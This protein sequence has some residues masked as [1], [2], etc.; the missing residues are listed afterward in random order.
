VPM[1]PGGGPSGSA[2]GSFLCYRLKCP[3]PFPPDAET[4]DQFG[5]KRV[6]S[7]RGAAFLCAR[8]ARGA[9]TIV[10][11]TTTTTVPGASQFSS[12]NH[13]CEGTCGNG[14]HCSAVVSG[15]ACECRTTPCGNADQPQCNGFCNP[16]EAC[17]VSVTGCS[18]ASIP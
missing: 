3:K 15:G 9:Q 14:G 18:C 10:S 13:R 2:A 6:V 11:S 7:F 17:I 16:D 4:T 12:A 5:G 8:A 1:P